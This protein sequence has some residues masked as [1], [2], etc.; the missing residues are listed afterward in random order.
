MLFRWLTVVTAVGAVAD[1]FSL[2]LNS[3]NKNH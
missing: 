3:A 1:P 2:D